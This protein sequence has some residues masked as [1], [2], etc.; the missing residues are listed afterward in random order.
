MNSIYG[1]WWIHKNFIDNSKQW[2]QKLVKRAQIT[3][4]MKLDWYNHSCSLVR[5]VESKK[6]VLFLPTWRIIYTSPW[7]LQTL[8]ICLK[9]RNTVESLTMLSI[10]SI[11]ASSDKFSSKTGVKVFDTHW[12]IHSANTFA[13]LMFQI[14]CLVLYKL[15]IPNHLR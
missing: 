3:A 10:L 6:Y 9:S 11:M 8:V 13:Q 2:I 1:R 14:L 4:P 15:K 5:S 7:S 12:L